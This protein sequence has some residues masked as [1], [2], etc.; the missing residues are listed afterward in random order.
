MDII[1]MVFVACVLLA[2]GAYWAGWIVDRNAAKRRQA[3]GTKRGS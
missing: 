2:V 3:Q 1:L